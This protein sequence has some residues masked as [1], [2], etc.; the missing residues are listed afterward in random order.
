MRK[1]AVAVCVII[2]FCLLAAAVAVCSIMLAQHRQ[3]MYALPPLT[4][5]ELDQL[6]QTMQLRRQALVAA[7]S[8]I[9]GGSTGKAA[10]DIAA[11]LPRRMNRTLDDYERQE[12]YR[13]T[14]HPKMIM[15][16]EFSPLGTVVSSIM[17]G[18]YSRELEL[19]R[20]GELNLAVGNW[21]KARACFSQLVRKSSP[22]WELA[23]AY[24]AEIEDDP[25]RAARHMELAS[26]GSN[27]WAVEMCKK[28][29]EQTGSVELAQYY[30]KLF[31]Q[32]QSEFLGISQP[33]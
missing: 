15:R 30:G 1:K 27:P 32:R 17:S 23:C 33:R 3:N 12:R 31:K 9:E 4:N 11:S 29:A 25:T 5:Q 13:Q 7:V 28:L 6:L 19:F 14:A 18:G 2:A 10:A 8:Q 21:T 16:I 26:A 22:G 20:C 24:L